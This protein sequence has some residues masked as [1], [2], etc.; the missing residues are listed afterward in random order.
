M[1]GLPSAQVSLALRG[2]QYEWMAETQP[3]PGV[4]EFPVPAFAALRPKLERNSSIAPDPEALRAFKS[5]RGK[6]WPDCVGN[7]TRLD[8]SACALWSG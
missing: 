2:A 8:R 5:G 3:M 7:G 1:P 6:F 4:D